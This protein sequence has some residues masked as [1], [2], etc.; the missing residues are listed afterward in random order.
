[1][2]V[3]GLLAV[4][5][6]V[7]LAWVGLLFRNHEL[8]ETARLR[9]FYGPP[10]TTQAE[11]E[12]DLQRL[13]DASRLDPDSDWELARAS[14]LQL[15]GS[16]DEALGLAIEVVRREPDNV[17]G[18][19]LLR[20]AARGRDPARAAQAAAKVKRLDPQAGG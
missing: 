18:W 1:M 15:S 6:V 13:E 7:V 16:P 5:A 11:R 3:R 9:A 8:G 17:I 19:M 14:Y 20:Q 10:P 12:R 4:V 2:A